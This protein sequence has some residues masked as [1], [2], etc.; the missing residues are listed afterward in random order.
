M[1][2]KG[3]AP[4]PTRLKLLKGNPGKH[5]LKKREPEPATVV[6]SVP[7][8]LE[9]DET[10]QEQ[11]D[12]LSRI[13]SD[14]TVLT[15]ADGLVPAALCQTFSRWAAALKQLQRSGLLYTTGRTGYVQQNPLLGIVN[16]CLAQ[17]NQMSRELGLTPGARSNIKTTDGPARP[18]NKFSLLEKKYPQRPRGAA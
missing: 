10:A 9:L 6:P 12:D 16:T 11:W 15:E 17:I 13:L 2:R 4:Q 5:P 8:G 1:A 14:M 18:E 7:R 3:P